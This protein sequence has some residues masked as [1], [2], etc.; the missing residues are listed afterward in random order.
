MKIALIGYGKMGRI[1]RDTA[2]E[3]GHT[4]WAIDP[5][6]PGADFQEIDEESLSGADLCIEFT[7]PECAAGNIQKA[8]ALG[9]NMVCGTTGWFDRL[10]EVRTLVEKAKIGF[11]HGSNF[12][13][14]VNLFYALVRRAAEIFDAF[15]EYDVGGVE[16]HHNRKAD[17]PSGTAKVLAEIILEETTQKKRPVYGTLDRPIRPDE[18]H[19]GS[20]R[21]GAHPGTHEVVFDS[22]TDTLSLKHTNR[23]RAGLALGA[24][25][26]AE[27]LKGKI[28]FFTFEDVM[29]DL[30]KKKS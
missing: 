30:I 26:A 8:A 19:F 2:R 9:K 13:F 25:K 27:W 10:D 6:A 17:S 28:G 22:E 11:L 15:P 16:F 29:N 7:H 23:S 5:N 20:V 21:C 18:L 12:S 14:G 3:R 1:V 4:V 24:V